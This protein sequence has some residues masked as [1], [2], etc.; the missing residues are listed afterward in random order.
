MGGQS[1]SSCVQRPRCGAS[2]FEQSKGRLDKALPPEKGLLV[3]GLAFR[4]GQP[5]RNLDAISTAHTC[6]DRPAA[7]LGFANL[8]SRK[9]GADLH[10]FL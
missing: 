10:W 4:T 7:R 3:Q 2:A 9:F 1:H 5:L 6:F 8:D